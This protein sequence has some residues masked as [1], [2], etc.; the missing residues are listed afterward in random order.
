MT[1]RRVYRFR[2]WAS[3]RPVPESSN[4]KWPTSD[5]VGALVFCLHVVY[6]SGG[7]MN[8]ETT[9]PLFLSLVCPRT[10]P[11]FRQ[12]WRAALNLLTDH[13]L[14]RWRE[15]TWEGR[16]MVD[17]EE[18]EEEELW[19]WY[20]NLIW[21]KFHWNSPSWYLE[22][23]IHLNSLSVVSVIEWGCRVARQRVHIHTQS[24]YS[25]GLFLVFCGSSKCT[26][27]M[28]DNGRVSI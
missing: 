22:S 10:A 16:W 17:E 19:C 5:D 24:V 7:W 2:G 12:K 4:S 21:L 6:C 11:M 26:P 28:N 13:W 1:K 25:G 15:K 18:E 23:I 3:P 8:E 14:D 9:P 27:E 20:N